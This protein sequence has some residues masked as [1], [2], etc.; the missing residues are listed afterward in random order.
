MK[1]LKLITINLIVLTCVYCC[2]KSNTGNVNSQNNNLSKDSIST[3]MKN[4]F[5]YTSDSVKPFYKLDADSISYIV[6]TAYKELSPENFGEKNTLIPLKEND[7]DIVLDTKSKFYTLE[8]FKFSDQNTAKLI[9][10]N[11]FGENDSKIL[12]VQLNSYMNNVLIDQLLLDC[13][14]TFETEYYRTFTI[15]KDKNIKLVKHTVDKLEYN[16][17]GDIVGEKQIGDSSKVTVDY[18]IDAAGK[19]IKN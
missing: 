13:R 2:K 8:T 19:F 4:N 15:N 17:A 16:D 10:Y 14:F 7:F 12:N 3:E 18:T 11:T 6:N 5:P 1:I 9:I